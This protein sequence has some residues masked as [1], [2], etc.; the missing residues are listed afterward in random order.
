MPGGSSQSTD[1]PQE[2]EKISSLIGSPSHRTVSARRL[3][4]GDG[5]G[6]EGRRRESRAT[7]EVRTRRSGAIR[8]AHRRSP[9]PEQRGADSAPPGRSRRP[10]TNSAPDT[11]EDTA[12]PER[13]RPRIR[14][15]S[16]ASPEPSAPWGSSRRHPTPVS[17]ESRVR[18]RVPCLASCAADQ[19]LRRH[20]IG[21]VGEHEHPETAGDSSRS[22]LAWQRTSSLGVRRRERARPR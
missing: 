21:A 2:S 3:A 17:Y 19:P 10:P 18:F 20:R 1:A 8:S 11:A 5:P 9:A 7:H 22:A 13:A 14:R 16:A 4:D 6:D 12:G 15:R